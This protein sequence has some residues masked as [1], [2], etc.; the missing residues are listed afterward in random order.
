MAVCPQ[1]R[2]PSP[3]PAV[4]AR[5]DL[6]PGIGALQTKSR[7]DSGSASSS[8]ESSG[9]TSV[10]G[11]ISDFDSMN[12]LSSGF[13]QM[14]SHDT[15]HVTNTEDGETYHVPS[16]PWEVNPQDIEGAIPLSYKI[17]RKLVSLLTRQP[18]ANQL[19][20]D[21]ANEEDARRK[22]AAEF[23]RDVR[24]VARVQPMFPHRR[25][26]KTPRMPRVGSAASVASA[27][28]EDLTKGTSSPEITRRKTSNRF[29]R[30]MS[31]NSRVVK[32]REP[33][34]AV[35]DNSSLPNQTDTLSNLMQPTTVYLSSVGDSEFL[36]QYAASMEEE[37]V[38]SSE[39][40][41]FLATM[42]K[43]PS[44]KERNEELKKKLLQ[45]SKK[46]QLRTSPNLPSS[47][48]GDSNARTATL[49]NKD[50]STDANDSDS[51]FVV[52][53]I[54]HCHE[55]KSHCKKHVANP[56]SSTIFQERPTEWYVQ[57]PDLLRRQMGLELSASVQLKPVVN[58]PSPIH[59]IT[60]SPLF[61]L[62]SG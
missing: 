58:P 21:C 56:Y 31:L 54:I 49:E 3:R 28:S 27:A 52:R 36:W 25:S 47:A 53:I 32:P 57:I 46:E 24:I 34:G 45:E 59:D 10:S 38:P 11:Y 19:R 23:W 9:N 7:S 48:S 16:M 20:E 1:N 40:V 12:S 4:P 15:G 43:Q 33:I 55:L 6:H 5:P 60:L 18:D 44:P 22:M 62:V 50:T 2:L 61:E 35:L 8:S 14:W 42:T 26:R 51:S 17:W 37:N 30:Q 41:T 13:D 39:Y 29:T